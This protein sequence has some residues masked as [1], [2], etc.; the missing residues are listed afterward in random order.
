LLLRWLLAALAVVS[1]ALGVAGIFIPGLPTTVFVLIAAWAA[2][3]SSPRLH[4]WLLGHR[5]FGPMIVAWNDGG[6]VSRRAKWSATAAMAVCMLVLFLTAHRV[7]VAEGVS[8]LML[9]ILLWLWRRP[10]P[11]KSG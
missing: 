1:L 10:E 8:L 7:W 4:A 9:V 3:R 2:S 11:P 5:V 6:R